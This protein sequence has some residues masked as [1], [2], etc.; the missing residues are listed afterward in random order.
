MSRTGYLLEVADYT[1]A[2]LKRDL[3]SGDIL[4]AHEVEIYP[5]SYFIFLRFRR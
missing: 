2:I 4:F 5:F 1:F 3:L